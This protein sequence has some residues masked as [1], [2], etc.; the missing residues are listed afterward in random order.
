MRVKVVGVRVSQEK[1][2]QPFLFHGVDLSKRV[3]GGSG[4]NQAIGECPFCGKSD[5]FYVNCESGQWQCFS[6]ALKGNVSSFLSQLLESSKGD[7]EGFSEL[8]NNRGL[9]RLETLQEWGVKKS[10]VSGE[11]LVPGY[12]HDKKLTQLYV[13]REMG[14]HKR[15]I[16]TKGLPHGLHGVNLYDS[17]KST[18]YLCEGAWDGMILWETLKLAKIKNANVLAVPSANVFRESWLPLF[19]GKIVCLMYDSDHPRKREDQRSQSQDG[20]TIAPVGFSAVKNLT[21]LLMTS[22]SKPKEV[23]YLKWGENGYDPDNPSGYDVREY[24]KALK[25]TVQRVLGLSPLL[26]KVEVAPSQWVE[27][28]LQRKSKEVKSLTPLE[29]ASWEV[30]VGAW[31]EALEWIEGL[32]RGLSVMLASIA[33]VRMPGDQ[34]WVKII[35]PAA[36]GKTTLCMALS[37]A[38]KYVIKKSV[39][40]GL[41]SGY[42][43]D[44]E[45]TEDQSLLS[46]LRDKTLLIKDGDT[47]L[48][49]PNLAQILSQLRDAYDTSSSTSYGNLMSRDYEG[50]RMT[51]ILCGTESLR[52]LDSTE[53]GERFLDCVM[54]EEIDD[55]IEDSIGL[56]AIKRIIEGRAI[57]ANGRVKDHQDESM[58]KAMRLTA[59]YVT[60]LRENSSRLLNSV[61]MTEKDIS[62]IMGLGKFVAYMRAKPSE[63][64]DKAATREMSTRL[65]VQLS[66]LALCLSI[67]LG[68]N[69]VDE[70]VIRR[71]RRVG[72]DTARGKT[73]ELSKHL[74]RVA[75]KGASTAALAVWLGEPEEKI[76][77]LLRFLR[78]LKVVELFTT[79][80]GKSTYSRWRLSERIMK[81]YREVIEESDKGTTNA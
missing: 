5:K 7:G 36:S 22:D 77:N 39:I 15:L 72:L 41:Y 64:G 37:V 28:F 40:R 74:Y 50:L 8:R 32:D 24:L 18:V 19:K 55:R 11:W 70:E 25:G 9:L 54:M 71:V 1:G 79:Q 12:N 45:G 73:L 51:L 59:G 16:P 75:N 33:S 30:L 49:S 21:G 20:K 42:Q 60:Y 14:G 4:G 17:K 68:T 65:R 34:L 56:R 26:R 46:K 10:L 38:R 66:R 58:T 78:K 13:Y 43:T 29:C 31:K 61:V 44:K 76:R 27:S 62:S 53:L 2:L 63:K 81:L 6:C 80:T 47:L 69:K 35:S 3:D 48:K 67:V 23:R 52:E 57:E